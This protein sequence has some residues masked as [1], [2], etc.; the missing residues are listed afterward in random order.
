MSSRAR[1]E[2][3]ITLRK[4]EGKLKKDGH[5]FCKNC[6]SRL[7]IDCG[8]AEPDFNEDYCSLGC[9]RDREKT[10]LLTNNNLNNK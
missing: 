2:R 10:N 1:W 8:E 9:Y 3:A 6:G 4:L 7:G 5:R